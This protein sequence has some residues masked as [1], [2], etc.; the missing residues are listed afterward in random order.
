MAIQSGATRP[1]KCHRLVQQRGQASGP[2]ASRFGGLPSW[3]RA[4][5]RLAPV[6]WDI[7]LMKL[8]AMQVFTYGQSWHEIR[9]DWEWHLTFAATHG[10]TQ[11][12]ES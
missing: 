4:G 1:Q 12:P 3:L 10:V 5:G 9:G 8:F 6:C 7:W 2:D 11:R